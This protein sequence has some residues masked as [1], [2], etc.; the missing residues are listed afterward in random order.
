MANLVKLSVSVFLSSDPLKPL[1]L[2]PA[3]FINLTNLM[4]LPSEDVS[5][6]LIEILKGKKKFKITWVKTP[7]NVGR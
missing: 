7:G 3:H 5:L 2:N 6:G 1:A 4:T